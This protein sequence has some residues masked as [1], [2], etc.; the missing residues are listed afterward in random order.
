MPWPVRNSIRPLIS[1]GNPPAGCNP[2]LW[3]DKYVEVGDEKVKRTELEKFIRLFSNSGQAYNKIYQRWQQ[4]FGNQKPLSFQ[5][6]GP[7]ALHLARAGSLENAGI[8]LHRLFGFPYI[9]G[10]GVKGLAH[11]WACTVWFPAQCSNAQSEDEKK[12]AWKMIVEVFGSAPSP[13]LDNPNRNNDPPGL[14]Q[15]IKETTGF[16]PAQEEG[17]KRADVVKEWTQSGLVVF[18]DAWPAQWPRLDIDILNCHHR[19]YY[20]AEEGK[21]PPP[22]DW[23][24][25]VPVYFPI[26]KKG[27]NFDFYVTPRTPG[28]P[29]EVLDKAKEWLKGG[30]ARLGAG[31]KTNSGYGIFSIER[32]NA[33]AVINSNHIKTWETTVHLVTPAFL[34]GPR[35]DGS[36]CDL[37]PATLRGLLRWWWRTL[38]AGHVDTAT[39]REMEN[40]LWGSASAGGAIQI[41]VGRNST[42]RSDLWNAK[43]FKRESLGLGKRDV[44]ALTYITFGMDDQ[45]EDSEKPARRYLAP[46]VAWDIELVARPVT[47]GTWDSVEESAKRVLSQA[48]AA[49]WLLCRFGGIGSKARR[50][51]GSLML[52]PREKSITD[53]KQC[54][55]EADAFRQ[56]CGCEQHQIQEPE[57][58]ALACALPIKDLKITGSI[59]QVFTTLGRAVSSFVKERRRDE[60]GFIYL[61]E[62]AALLGLPRNTDKEFAPGTFPGGP[63]GELTQHRA[64]EREAREKKG[65]PKPLL[66]DG[67]YASPF[68]F[69]FDQKHDGKLLLHIIAFPAKYLPDWEKSRET[70][71]EFINHL[72]REIIASEGSDE[73]HSR[74][75]Q[76]RQPRAP[77]AK[78]QT[79]GRPKGPHLEKV[80]LVRTKKGTW[81]AR[82]LSTGVIASIPNQKDVPANAQEEQEITLEV[83]TQD[84]S[85]GK[86]LTLRMPKTE[87]G[88]TKK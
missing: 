56:Q 43:L 16:D 24:D 76:S 26:I 29:A 77:S 51:F 75:P 14:L 40:A 47:I 54:L 17:R 41:R 84:S 28:T 86:I 11:A 23:E 9:P 52:L 38:H 67:R 2:S 82:V 32:N 42:V 35:Q 81:G 4:A 79:Q 72:E 65:H 10:N 1:N 50:G 69:H 44:L 13:W 73:F 15:W 46:G 87:A 31:G 68:H 30:L 3:L 83:A 33:P 18:H 39:L 70:I 19:D 74:G 78:H 37:R 55:D 60:K 71:Q 59:W 7:M 48:K 64:Q 85:T 34:A 6:A 63:A 49:L 36:D 58:S 22:G 25:P 66:R 5:T 80:I 53:L 57:T 61:R 8:C 20:G 88:K 62:R 27:A 45:A 21:V 12:S